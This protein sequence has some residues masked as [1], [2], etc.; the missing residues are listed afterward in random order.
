METVMETMQGETEQLINVPPAMLYRYVLDFTRHP[1]WVANLSKVSQITPGAIGVGTIFRAQ[2]GP[3]PVPLLTKLRMMRHFIFGL[4]SGA[5]PYSQAEITA[6]EPGQRIAWRAGIP[7]GAGYF[8]LAE[9]ELILQ[10]QGQATRLIQRFC[11][12]PQALGA[13]RMIAAAGV[14]GIEQAC[15]VNLVRLQAVAEQ[16][17]NHYNKEQIA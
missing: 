2:E 15:T 8:N 1:E 13:A 4:L 12:R 16:Q 6:L 7:R 17:L 9:W 5:K 11:Y 14:G 3:P 10:P